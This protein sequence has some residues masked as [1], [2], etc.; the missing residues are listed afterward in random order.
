MKP[1]IARQP[2]SLTLPLCVL[3]LTLFGCRFAF[4]PAEVELS[5]SC[6][7]PV[8]RWV[9]GLFGDAAIFRALTVCLFVMLNGLNITRIISS[10]LVLPARNYLPFIF[11]V[12]ISCGIYFPGAD[13]AAAFASYLIV[14]ASIGFIGS[15][16][17]AHSF[18]RIFGASLMLGTI[19]LLHAPSAIYMLL[20]PMAMSI[21]R[22]SGRE[23][24][25]AIVGLLFPLFIYAYIGWFT[26]EEFTGAFT[27]I[28]HEIVSTDN[29][30]MLAGSPAEVM[31]WAV[32]GVFG[33]MTLLSLVTF[34]SISGD[35]RTTAYKVFI[36][37]I[38]FLGL[39]VVS[40]ALPCRSPGGLPFIAIPAAFVIPLFFSRHRGIFSAAVYVLSLLLVTALNV[41]PFLS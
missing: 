21:F 8:G 17:R 6:G 16:T 15:F 14:K 12:M 10:K 35:M 1:D 2:L 19:P 30:I 37:M 5:A 27:T 18:G 36:Y 23:T 25:V 13:L 40:A 34:I 29:G 41:F 26:G 9:N 38:C 39:A 11:Y 24:L 7:M 31:K 32:I 4:H 33:L 20:A 28:W 22:R 3:L